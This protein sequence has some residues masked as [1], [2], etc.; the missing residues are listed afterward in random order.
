MMHQNPESLRKALQR[1]KESNPK[2]AKR[3]SDARLRAAACK[4]VR[5]GLPVAEVALTSGFGQATIKNWLTQKGS[6]EVQVLTVGDETPQ[7]HETRPEAPLA[8]LEFGAFSL[9]LFAR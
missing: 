6:A 1:A 8:S 2:R 7:A 3:R 4:A 5:G 9:R